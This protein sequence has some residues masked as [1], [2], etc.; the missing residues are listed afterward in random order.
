LKR[1]NIYIIT[2]VALLLLQACAQK[3]QPTGG[4]KDII[5][6][7]LIS[8]T[9]KNQTLNFVGKEV[10][11]IF[12]E[13]MKVD[14]INQNLLITPSVDA[15]YKV[16]IK[17][18]GAKITFPD[19]AFKANTTYSL[20]FRSTFKDFSEG[21][22]AKN[23]RIVFSTG[24]VIDSLKVQGKIHDAFTAQPS[25][26]ALVGLYRKHDSLNI[27]KEKPYYFTKTDSTGSYTLENI[28]AGTYAIYAFKDINNNTV[29]NETTESI[30][31]Q[32][33]SIVLK[34]NIESLMLQLSYLNKNPLKINRSSTTTSTAT[35]ELSKQPKQ[36]HIKFLNT[37]SLG[38]AWQNKEIKIYNTKSIS[39][40]L[41]LQITVLDSAGKTFTLPQKLL[42]KKPSNRKSDSPADPLLMQLNHRAGAAI[43]PLSQYQISFNKPIISTNIKAIQILADSIQAINLTDSNLL[44]NAYKTQLTIRLPKTKILF[45]LKLQKAAF[46]SVLADSSLALQQD[47][48]LLLADDTGIISGSILQANGS[49]IVQLL[50]E[51][52]EVVKEKLY[53][54]DFIFNFIP[55]GKY[56]LAII[57]DTNKNGLWDPGNWEIKLQP[58]KIQYYKDIIQIKANFELSGYNF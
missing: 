7:K 49:Q 29:Y 17:P 40:T 12:D 53:K 56:R 26:D 32:K 24:A 3:A 30:G 37:D 19:T 43:E 27:R 4:K 1:T 52:N 31:F 13:Y 38:Y 10:E 20:N 50:N 55:P 46:I 47:N 48:P 6:P 21:N 18:N 25:F 8:S 16:K 58:E 41:K 33:D 54:K 36:L 2:C 42:F 35:I 51:K 22:E 57:H 15:P 34:Q 14:N 11:L 9:P 39:D 28:Q 44:W 23:I 45:R 5:A